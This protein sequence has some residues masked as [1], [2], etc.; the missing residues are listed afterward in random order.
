MNKKG[1]EGGMS[2]FAILIVAI[3]FILVFSGAIAPILQVMIP[4]S[5]TN[6]GLTGLEAFLIANFGL[7][8]FIIF[9]I[10]VLWWSR[11]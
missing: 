4:I 7:W 3:I 8:I 11:T 6:G 2:I 1:Q 10:A 9:I 5:I